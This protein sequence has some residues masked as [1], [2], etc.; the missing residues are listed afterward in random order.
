MEKELDLVKGILQGQ[1]LSITKSITAVENN[2]LQTNLLMREV[3]K[4]IGKGYRVGITGPPGA[5]KSTLISKLAK[6]L[7]G[8]DQ[9]VAILA[10]DPT[11]PFTG[12]AFLGDRIRMQ[13]IM[14]DPN[15]FIRSMA[16]RGS[17]GGL[18]KKTRE[19]IDIL[20][21]GGFKTIL[22]ETVGVGQAE[23]DIASEA[24]TT[25]LVLTPTSGDEIQAN[26]S[27]IME[28]ADILVVN[29]ADNP[30]CDRFITG[31]RNA[32]SLGN[33]ATKKPEIIKS[34]ATENKGIEDIIKAIAKQRIYLE[35]SSLLNQKRETRL[36]NRIHEL[37]DHHLKT[38]FW[39][40]DKEGFLKSKLPEI[41][42]QKTSIYD[43]FNQLI[44]E[45]QNP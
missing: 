34:V 37:V 30:G 18:S 22:I 41:L 44:Q 2:T 3:S 38:Q 26:K 6:H 9:Q 27:G 8:Q 32:L 29:K 19:A 24:D 39:T 21:A 42:E 4:Y 28:I 14:T 43:V 36:S 12:G 45:T 7:T 10:I 25:I 35:Q 13:E 16:S 31:L 20:D 15:V 23:L 40:Q 5:G 33:P 11:S 1:I 17:L